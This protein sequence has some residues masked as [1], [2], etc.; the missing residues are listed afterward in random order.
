MQ[1]IHSVALIPHVSHK[2]CPQATRIHSF[3]SLQLAHL[4]HTLQRFLEVSLQFI[5]INTLTSKKSN[6]IY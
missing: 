4:S 6:L 2:L 3:N 1:S 5:H